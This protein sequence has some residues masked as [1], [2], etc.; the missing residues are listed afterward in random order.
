M[1]P[2]RFLTGKFHWNDMIKLSWVKKNAIIQ[3]EDTFPLKI[4][5][6]IA[7]LVTRASQ[8]KKAT[9]HIASVRQ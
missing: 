5:S 4:T 2:K 9:N 7:L 6:H 8:K 3:N 1:I